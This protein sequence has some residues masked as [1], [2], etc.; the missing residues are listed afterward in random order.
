MGAAGGRRAVI[1]KC[2]SLKKGTVTDDVK[3]KTYENP[4]EEAM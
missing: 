4:S 3:V 2:P 1:P